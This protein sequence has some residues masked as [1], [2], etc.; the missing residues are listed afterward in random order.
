MLLVGGESENVSLYYHM[1][2][3]FQIQFGREEF[4]LVTGLKFGVEYSDD[5]DENDKPVPFRRRVFSSCLD[6]NRITGKDVEDLI[7]RKS[8]KKLDDDGAVSL[9]YI[10]ILQLV[11]LGLEDRL[12]VPSWILRLANDR[13]GWDDYPWG[14]YVWPALYYQLNDANVKCWLPLYAT[15]STNEDDK[16]SYSIFGFTW[17]FKTWILEVFRLGPNEYYTRHM[18]YPVIVAWTSNKKFYRPMLRDFLHQ[19]PIPSHPG[20]AGL[21]DPNIL[22]RPRRVQRPSVYIQSP[23]TPLPTTKLPKKR[24]GRTKKNSKNDNLSP[25][26]LGNAFAHDNV[27]GDDVLRTG[28]HDTVVPRESEIYWE[29]IRYEMGKVFYKCRCENT[30][31]DFGNFRFNYAWALKVEGGFLSSCSLLFTI[32]HPGGHQYGDAIEAKDEFLKAYEQ[33][34]D[35]SMDKRAM[36]ENFLKIESELDYEMQSALFRK[37]ANLEKQIRDKLDDN[38]DIT[39]DHEVQFF[40]ECACNSKD[41]VA[42]FKF[43]NNESNHQNESLF[44]KQECSFA[45]GDYHEYEDEKNEFDDVVEDNPLP[46]YQKWQKYMSSFKTDIPETPLY[47]SKP[48]ISKHYKKETDVKVCQN[49][50]NKEALD[51]TIRLKALDEGYQFLNDRS[52]PERTKKRRD[53][54]TYKNGQKRSFRDVMHCPWCIDEAHLKG[55]YKGTNLMAAGIDGN[56]QIV[57]IAF[58]M[59]KGK[60]GP[61]W[62][63]WMFVLKECIGDNPSLLFISDKH[64][65]IALAV[66]NEF[67]LACHVVCFRHLLMNLSLKGDKKALVWIICKAYTTK[68]FSSSMSHLQDIQ[69][70]AYDKLCQEA[71]GVKVNRDILC[72]G[73]RLAL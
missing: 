51:L 16:K 23:Y 69:P 34:R 64:A 52:A 41:E 4:C 26:N 50:E 11:L 18:R 72:N 48:M 39:D 35:I 65:A 1:Y 12:A 19:P 14:S 7:E 58:G 32:P 30:R 54:N 61:C 55:Q 67:P 20:D 2:D 22:E 62:S 10:G 49:F 59:C 36:I 40:V 21:C 3:N 38:F 13:D 45:F 68:E 66:Q 43:H 28:V 57:P 53:I 5:Y 70:D 46:N 25:L 42:H 6:G 27:A 33:C 17:A 63:W 24:V 44:E 47:K 8:F 31:F 9:C 71:T 15:E 56:N 37:A 73:A 29:N 60:T